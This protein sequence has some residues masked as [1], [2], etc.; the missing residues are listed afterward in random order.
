[1]HEPVATEHRRMKEGYVVTGNPPFS[2]YEI[3]ARF[4]SLC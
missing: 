4:E 1:M 2:F 3:F